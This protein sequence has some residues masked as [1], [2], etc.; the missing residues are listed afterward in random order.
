MYEHLIK[1]ETGNNLLSRI[2]LSHV[3]ADGQGAE[4]KSCG[5]CA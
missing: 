3:S 2:E 1:E 5:T 4:S